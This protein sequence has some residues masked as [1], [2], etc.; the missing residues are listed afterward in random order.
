[1]I[2][3]S[4]LR[5]AFGEKVAVDIA[6]YEIGSG[7][8]IGLVGNNGAGK[9]TLFRLML[10]LLKA[11]DGRVE[12]DFGDGIVIDPSTSEEWKSHTGA[13]IDDGFL[14]DFLTPEEYFHFIGK[15]SSIS[16]EV[17]DERL[18]GY[19]RLMAGEI[20]GQ[21]KLIRDLSA[22]NKHKVGIISALIKHP[23]LVILDE[24]FNFLD[25]SSQNILKHTLKE[26]NKATGAS[27]IISSHNLAHTIDISSR[28]TLMEHGHIIKDLSNIDHSATA[29]L[30]AYFDTEAE[31]DTEA[32]TETGTTAE[33]EA[34]TGAET[35]PDIA[36][37]ATSSES[38][39]Q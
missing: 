32:D 8:L 5:K 14:I 22:G 12:Y 1:M 36:Q 9:T 30:E 21:K 24:P 26:Y 34:E 37:A 25:P 33:I 3:I 15:V 13:Y 39:P 28:I 20:M 29:E 31:L 10:D 6:T 18:R 35:T 2:S 19:E 16:E 11:N 38:D 17:I 23:D 4:N 7:E 27:I